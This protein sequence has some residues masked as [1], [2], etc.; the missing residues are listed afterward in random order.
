MK[1]GRELILTDLDGNE[2]LSN[3]QQVKK[4]LEKIL[5]NPEN[6]TMV[7]YTR[8]LISPK[9][10][11]TGNLYHSFYVVNSNETQY[12][13]LSFSATRKGKYS[14]GA[15]AMNTSSDIKSYI[16]YK[17]GTNEWDVQDIIIT[18][19]INTEKTIRNII[20]RIDGDYTYYYYDHVKDK[21]NMENCNTALQNTLIENI[22][23][24]VLLKKLWQ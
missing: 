23:R 20:H 10:E 14:T 17:Q 7:G 1:L 3:E 19:G 21:D 12:F 22:S 24:N 18:A 4:H 16:S 15:W 8:R 6:Y 5:L 2:L 9:I 11:R 13:T